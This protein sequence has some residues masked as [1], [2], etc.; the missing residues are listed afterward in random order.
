[1]FDDMLLKEA[2][3]QLREEPPE[4]G[5]IVYHQDEPDVLGMVIDTKDPGGWSKAEV[6]WDGSQVSEWLFIKCLKVLD[7]ADN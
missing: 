5:D 6:A 2:L 1:M 3:L 4:R 7:K